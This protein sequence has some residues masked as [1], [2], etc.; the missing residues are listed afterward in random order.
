MLPEVP[1]PEL[2]PEDEAE[3]ESDV[4]VPIPVP[5]DPLV[6]ELPVLLR[7]VLQFASIMASGNTSSTFFIIIFFNVPTIIM[8]STF[9]EK[10]RV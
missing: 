3:E 2:I 5:E 4:P 9:L 1:D 6:P 8:P 7:G 10:K